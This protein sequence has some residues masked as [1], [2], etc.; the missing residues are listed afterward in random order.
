MWKMLK[1]VYDYLLTIPDRL[2]PFS[3]KT[4]TG[5]VLSGEQAYRYLFQKNK[6]LYDDPFSIKA[7]RLLLWRSVFHVGGS[8]ILLLIADSMFDHLSFFNGFAFLVLVVGCIAVQEFYLHPRYYGQKPLKGLIDF[9]A[10][11]LPIV[12]YILW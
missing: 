5:V 2:Y 8:I 9:T 3:E 11:V 7:P 1:K 10:W 4:S 6:E 12:L